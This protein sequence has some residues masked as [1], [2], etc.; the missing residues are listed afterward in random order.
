MRARIADAR[1]APR[2]RTDGA[3][4]PR[5]SARAPAPRSAR[6]SSPAPRAAR[7]PRRARRARV[8][9]GTNAALPARDELPLPA[10]IARAPRARAPRARRSRRPADRAGRASAPACP[11]P[12]LWL[13][14]SRASASALHFLTSVVLVL[15]ERAPELRRHHRRLQPERAA[16]GLAADVDA[17]VVEERRDVLGRVAIALQP[18]PQRL[19]QR[20]RLE[21]AVLALD[22]P[23]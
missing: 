17:R 16:R 6:G 19:G 18:A 2:R 9:P 11:A 12:A 7:A 3:G 22:A 14:P 15:R 1:R 23:P 13:A 8:A 4:R 20:V 21:L 5:A 10:R